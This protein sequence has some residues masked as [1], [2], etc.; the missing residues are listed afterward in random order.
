MKYLNDVHKI[1]IA[2]TLLISCKQDEEYVTINATF[3]YINATSE[4]IRIYGGCGFDVTTICNGFQCFQ[5][6]LSIPSNDTIIVQQSN[7]IIMKSDKPSVNNLDLFTTECWT[8]YGDSL[9][10]DVNGFSGIRGLENYEKREEVSKNSFEFTYRFT[11][12]TMAAA[13]ECK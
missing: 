2:L 10:C 5:L 12:E 1:L 7:R 11:E 3:N 8:I 6:G 9:K 13:Q 4:E